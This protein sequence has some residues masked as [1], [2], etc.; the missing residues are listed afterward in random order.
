MMVRPYLAVHAAASFPTALAAAYPPVAAED[1]VIEPIVRANY[2]ARASDPATVAV[3][4]TL[5]GAVGAF[6]HEA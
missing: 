4:D 6:Y 2:R 3:S 1:L 5:R